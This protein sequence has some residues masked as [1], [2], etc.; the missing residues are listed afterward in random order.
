MAQRSFDGRYEWVDG[1]ELEGEELGDAVVDP[2]GAARS[3]YN[4]GDARW[5]DFLKRNPDGKKPQVDPRNVE[6]HDEKMWGQTTQTIISTTGTGPAAAQIDQIVQ[7]SRP[8]RVWSAN[9]AFT[10]PQN[11]Q[12]PTLPN[13]G[14]H[15]TFVFLIGTGTGF[16][17]RYVE[18]DSSQLIAPSFNP[19]F[20]FA[21]PPPTASGELLNFPARSVIVSAHILYDRILI[22]APADLQVQLTAQ[23]APIE[24]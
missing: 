5:G 14:V 22:A 8:A 13:F 24:R 10:L 17:T 6:Q 7:A 16:I 12:L 3:F 9:V 19:S 2:E 21:T 20:P 11:P 1:G 23:V 18:L 4:R 15:V